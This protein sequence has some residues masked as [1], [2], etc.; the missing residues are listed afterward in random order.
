MNIKFRGK[1][2]S[3]RRIS[4]TPGRFKL[5]DIVMG[6]NGMLLEVKTVQRDCPVWESNNRSK[7]VVVFETEDGTCVPVDNISGNYTLFRR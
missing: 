5:G 2:E 7:C 3:C 1:I 6:P 4:T